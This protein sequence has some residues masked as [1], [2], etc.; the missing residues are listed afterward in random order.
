MKTML[1][2][3]LLGAGAAIAAPGDFDP[4]FGLGG[5]AT[6]ATGPAASRVGEAA[7]VIP[8][9]DGRLLAIGSVPN[10]VDGPTGTVRIFARFLPDG[11]PD[12]GLAGTGYLSTVPDPAI[13]RNGL[14]AF[15]VADGKALLVE[16]DL[17]LCWPPRPACDAAFYRPF[18]F[19]Q[20]I[21]AAGGVDPSYGVMATVSSDIV[22]GDAT[23]S[24]DGSLTVVG[25]RYPPPGALPGN[26][27]F[28]VRGFDR[29]GQID[30]R[31]IEA[32]DAFD[33]GGEPVDFASS[34]KLA[35]QADGRILLAQQVYDAAGKYRICISRL[36][37]D[38]TLDASF[39]SAGRLLLDTPNPAGYHEFLA[40]IA[41]PDGGA[42]LFL[43]TAG[44]PQGVSNY[45]I[46]VTGGG[47]PDRTRGQGGVVP[48]SGGPLYEITAAAVQTDNKVL[49]AGYPLVTPSAG[50]GT[51]VDRAAPLVVRLDPSTGAP[52]PS[53]GSAG[54]GRV[55][56]AT[57]GRRFH[58]RHIH[59]GAG[60]VL[61][62]AGSAEAAGETPLSAKRFAIARLAGD[63]PPRD[64]GGIW[65]GGCGTTRD[66]PPDPTLPTLTL[67]AAALLFRRRKARRCTT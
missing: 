1:A 24:P 16:Q 2:L 7:F 8:D 55:S 21:D 33:C 31:W 42:V 47:A 37:P 46:W 15:P 41:R 30:V 45:M 19:A 61:Y 18:L 66:G 65:G 44:F 43:E 5:I 28:E 29:F 4:A 13:S 63:P 57:F 40:L 17:L 20:R 10:A 58:P 26:P 35:R 54:D 67:L 6:I 25:Y 32:R 34:A 60:N 9:A 53:F 51:P 39:G 14:Q 52:D 22:Q 12:A 62:L 3:L 64:R 49:L 59:V 36:F 38:A 56:L 23:A 11:T 27:Q 50:P 48:L